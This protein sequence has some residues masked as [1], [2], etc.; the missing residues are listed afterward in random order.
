MLACNHTLSMI[1]RDAGHTIALYDARL[2]IEIWGRVW[3]SHNINSHNNIHR[4]CTCTCTCILY[5]I[6]CMYVIKHKFHAHRPSQVLATK[7]IDYN[8][9]HASTHNTGLELQCNPYI[10]DTVG[11]GFIVR[12]PLL[13]GGK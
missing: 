8:Y 6:L 11:T 3:N 13:R 12:C 9:I 1:L 7:M 10:A 4:T 2:G 5:V